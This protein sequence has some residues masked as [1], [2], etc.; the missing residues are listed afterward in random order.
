M[1][2]LV[3]CLIYFHILESDMHVPLDFVIA[4]QASLIRDARKAT[5]FSLDDQSERVCM[6]LQLGGSPSSDGEQG[7]ETP[8]DREQWSTWVYHEHRKRLVCAAIV[9]FVN[10][11]ILPC[12]F[13]Q[14]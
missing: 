11:F 6:S 1:H 14:N 12:P 5:L 10:H 4:A 3:R 8:L 13:V 7:E 9:R 2:L